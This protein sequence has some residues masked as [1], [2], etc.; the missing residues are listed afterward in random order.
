MGAWSVVLSPRAESEVR[1]L[2]PDMQARFLRVAELLETFG[3]QHVGRPHVRPLENKLWEMRLSGQ[4][5][6]ARAIYFAASGQRVVVVRAFVKKSQKTPQREI[7]IARQ[8][9]QEWQSG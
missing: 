1:A 6:I 9:M 3:P 2:P 4:S 5:G 8:R 7:A